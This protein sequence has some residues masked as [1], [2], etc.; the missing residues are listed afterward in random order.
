MTTPRGRRVPPL[1][2]LAA[3]TSLRYGLMAGRH[4]WH[5][6]E[7]P[8]GAPGMALANEGRGRVWIKILRRVSDPLRRAMN[9]TAN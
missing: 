1:Q 4:A 9:W 8:A 7:M 5:P 2:L 3:T 6:T